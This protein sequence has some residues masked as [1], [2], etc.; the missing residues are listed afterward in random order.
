MPK[1]TT[2]VIMTGL[3]AMMAIATFA[4]I[5]MVAPSASAQNFPE[6]FDT[7]CF[8]RSDP[9]NREGNTGNA[10]DAENPR[11]PHDSQLGFTK[12]NPHDEC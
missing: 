10:Q 12:G 3:I 6:G 8:P 11:N 9:A 5:M 1:A 7:R 4:S 2:S